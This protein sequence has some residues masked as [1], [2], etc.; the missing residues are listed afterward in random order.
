MR[1]C[2]TCTC[3]SSVSFTS[4]FSFSTRRQFGAIPVLVSQLRNPDHKVQVSVLGALRNL[5]FG[6]SNEENK[7]EIAGE[8]GLS[9]IMLALRMSRVPE[10]SCVWVCVW[11]GG[12]VWV[13]VG[14]CGCVWVGVGVGG[15]V[16]GCTCSLRTRPS[17]IEK[18]GLVN[19]LGWK[20]TLRPVCRCTSNWVLIS[21]LMCVN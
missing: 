13:W 19:Q 7:L 11:G 15:W 2:L 20:C 5:S 3:I 18:E 9:E 8:H 1:S 6:R 12:G 21:I 17:K 16:G 10:V 4:T 14:V